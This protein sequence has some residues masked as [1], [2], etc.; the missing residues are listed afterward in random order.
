MSFITNKNKFPPQKNNNP[1]F[2]FDKKEEESIIED[3]VE[4]LEIQKLKKEKLN[5]NEIIREISKLE[6]ENEKLKKYKKKNNC[7]CKEDK[8]KEDKCK[9][10]KCKEDKCK[11]DKCKDCCESI[12]KQILTSLIFFLKGQ[13]NKIVIDA[14]IILIFKNG[15]TE[16]FDSNQKI[17]L[18][19]INNSIKISSEGKM[20]LICIESIAYISIQPF[21][22][23][24]LSKSF[25]Y[26]ELNCE[27]S[28]SS[29]MSNFIKEILKSNLKFE[30][31]GVIVNLDDEYCTLIHDS[32]VILLLRN[33]GTI[34]IFFPC[35]IYQV[36]TLTDPPPPPLTCTFRTV[37]QG[38]WG[39]P[40]NG[41]NPGGILANN[42]PNTG[43]I[44]GNNTRSI[45]FSTQPSV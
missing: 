32:S 43:F 1:V 6:K 17:T 41:N 10:D 20:C 26:D 19:L 35:N 7:K 23:L 30:I 28:C 18:E 37:T 12:I 13:N 29:N 42:F 21:K 11:E 24:I 15:T 25:I 39:S 44:I 31:N 40:P 3:K 2:S 4:K 16:K 5:I 8:C 9:E 22:D 27:S 36:C 45:K 33:N 14:N 38:G 34:D